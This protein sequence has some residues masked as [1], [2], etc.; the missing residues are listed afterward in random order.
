M[1]ASN[2]AA[3][4]ALDKARADAHEAALVAWRTGPLAEWQRA[5][6]AARAEKTDPPARPTPP[7][8]PVLVQHA[9]IG[10]A[11]HYGLGADDL[12]RFARQTEVRTKYPD[13]ALEAARKDLGDEIVTALRSIAWPEL[14]PALPPAPVIEPPEME[15]APR[16]VPDAPAKRRASPEGEAAEPEEP[17]PTPRSTEEAPPGGDR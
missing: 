10:I 7:S 14:P 1:D 9:V 16:A 12:V 13:G 4:V 17:A 15:R 3:L 11:A 6:T 5:D 2:H 8:P